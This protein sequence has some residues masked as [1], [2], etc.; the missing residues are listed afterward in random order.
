MLPYVTSESSVVVVP[1]HNF[2]A[3]RTRATLRPQRCGDTLKLE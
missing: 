2:K 1:G 3:G